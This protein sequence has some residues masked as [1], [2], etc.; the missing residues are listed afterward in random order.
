[1]HPV[2]GYAILLVVLFLF[3]IG[4][5]R[6]GALL[7]T[8][9]LQQFSGLEAAIL[10]TLAS[11]STSAV[12]VRG[13]LQGI[14]GGL[15][16][17]L[18]YLIPFLLGLALLEDIG[19]LPRVAF[20]MDA[21]MHRI[22]LHGT[23]VLPLI[24]GYGC[25][26]PAVMATRILHSQRDRFIAAVISIL[27]PCSARTTV[28][29]ALTGFYLGGAWAFGLYILNIL[30]VALCGRILSRMMPQLIPGMI[31]EVPRYQWPV[32]QLILKK[33]WFRMREFVRIAW[34]LLIAGSVILAVAQNYGWTDGIN[35]AFSPL[36]VSVLGLPAVVG[37]TL[38]F[39]VLRK[40]MSLLMLVAALGTTAISTVMTATQ[41]LTFTVFVMFYIP[42]IATIGV[43]I[44]EIGKRFTFFAAAYTFTL[45]T[46]AAGLVR[47]LF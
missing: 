25:S 12:V 36:T 33:T 24:L 34:P 6:F 35:R 26:V 21:F 28:I 37:T 9:L 18:P 31:L 47:L 8:A 45:A 17:V 39:G 42:C 14:I 46:V 1:M 11:G 19:Y 16:I 23:A 7:E 15:A 3:F 2:W 41:I 29:L 44:R 13:L 4:V 10:S 22:G 27:V 40:E 38:I 32:P 5:F 30:V 20:L 43:L